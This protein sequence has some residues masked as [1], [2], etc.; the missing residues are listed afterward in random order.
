LSSTGGESKDRPSITL[1]SRKPFRGGSYG[2]RGTGASVGGAFG[3]PNKK[4]R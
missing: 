3:N 1:N 2:R 4:R